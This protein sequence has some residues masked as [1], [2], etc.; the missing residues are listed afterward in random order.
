[1][2]IS[3]K[4]LIDNGRPLV[5]KNKNYYSA[6]QYINPFIERMSRY[7]DNFTVQV[8]QPDTM[9]KSLDGNDLNQG[10]TRVNVEAIL[11]D[12]YRYEGHSQVVGFIYALDTR[13]PIVKEYAGAI[14]TACLNLCTFNPT[15]L[16][17]QELEPESG[18][19]YSFLDN[20]MALSDN[21]SN[22]LR[23]LSSMDVT[24]NECYKEMGRWID[25]CLTP[26]IN[27]FSTV[28]GKVKL[29]ETLPIEVYKNLFYNNKSDYY[30]T[31]D[32]VSGFNIYQAFTDL[33]CNGNK[34]DLVN[35]FEKVLLV[36]N[37]MGLGKYDF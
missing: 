18:I 12:E 9:T 26:D 5:I 14:R 23:G 11:P 3:L 17:V 28:G 20:C 25:N 8:K 22:T 4:E 34:R 29:S 33:I 1:M 35:R 30:T 6:E 7:T 13:K 21:I 2:E 27:S 10:F 31:D 24:K 16:Q 36:K 15:A 32:H 37:I 19:N